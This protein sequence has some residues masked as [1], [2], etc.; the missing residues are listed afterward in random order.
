MVF[1][2]GEA[3]T[4]AGEIAPKNAHSRVQVRREFWKI[5][6]QLQRSPQP[7]AGLL[8]GFRANQKIQLVAVPGEESRG[9]ITAQVAGRAGYEDRHKG[10]EGVAALESAASRAGSPDQS[11]ARGSRDSSGRPSING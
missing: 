6:M 11:S 5:K 1:V 7:L 10:S 8:L 4:L 2:V 3:K 9:K